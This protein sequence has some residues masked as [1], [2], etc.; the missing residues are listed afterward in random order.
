MGLPSRS[1]GA[2]SNHLGA[3]VESSDTVHA[4]IGRLSEAGLRQQCRGLAT[5]YDKLAITYRAAAVLSAVCTWLRHLI[6]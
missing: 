5:R 1:T 6:N 3:E 2:V 4:E